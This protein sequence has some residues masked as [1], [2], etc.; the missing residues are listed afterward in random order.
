M[1][2]ETTTCTKCKEALPP[3]SFHKNAA[4]KNGLCSSCKQCKAKYWQENK[5]RFNRHGREYYAYNKEKLRA[6]NKKWYDNNKEDYNKRKR[7]ERQAL[8][9]E[10][11]E[12]YGNRCT[13][14][15]ETETVFLAIDHINNDGAKHRKSL[16]GAARG[17][18]F[19]VW[20]K[21]NGYPKDNFQLLC[22]NCNWAKHHGGCPHQ[23]TSRLSFTHS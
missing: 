12:E 14:C 6:R 8:K 1:A 19:Y 2:A 11:F 16:N 21:N 22:W 20:L 5:D 13:C 10:V 23:N 3:S 15:G 4:R 18:P 17:Y 7:E 9:Q